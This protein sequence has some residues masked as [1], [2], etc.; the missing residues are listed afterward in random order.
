MGLAGPHVTELL[1]ELGP[2]VRGSALRELL[3]LPPRDVLL[4]L[5]PPACA[6]PEDER[7]RRLRVSAGPVG[8]RLHLQVGRVPRHRGPADPFFAEVAERLV[9]LRLAG[10]RQV[11]GDR[12]VRL[13][14]ADEE[15]RGR[16]V[17]VAE[18][19]G[20]HGNLVLLDHRDR[21]VEIL[22]PAR[23]K[24]AEAPR[25]VPGEGYAL[26][27]GR[28]GS[29]ADVLPLE[30]H[31]PAPPPGTGLAA[32][33]PLSWRVESSLGAEAEAALAEEQ[34]RDLSHRLQRRLKSA[35]KLLAGLAAL[36][37]AA[38][39]AERLRRDGELLKS[40]LPKLRRGAREVVVVDWFDEAAPSRTIPLDPKLSPTENLQR[41]FSRHQKLLRAAD[42]LPGEREMAAASHEALGALLERV[43]DPDT[44]PGALEEEAI[45][46]GWLA[47]RQGAPTRRAAPAKRLPYRTFTG[48]HGGEIRVGRSARD[49]DRLS[50]RESRGNDLWL[51]TSEAPGSHVVLRLAKGREPDPEDVLDAAHL[52]VHFSPLRGAAKA[53]IHVARV[54]E[55]KKPKKAPAGLV[56][57]AGGKVRMIR[58]EE[59][60]LRRLLDRRR[61]G[62]PRS[63]E[64]AGPSGP[65]A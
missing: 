48:L 1:A 21:V 20:R 50:F 52:A 62:P 16:A 49:N 34:R 58:I 26:P 28:T 33:A 18:L 59:D 51:H 30:R 56:T 22:V 44:D 60:R 23:G 57:L 10:L 32:L 40:E 15:G 25:L 64:D 12:V 45:A 38:A 11:Q 2:L 9:G 47:P 6:A 39:D 46:G 14:F 13:E 31:L 7:I 5:G 43:R 8:A 35:E 24:Q 54:K 61:P 53:G 17:L 4:V 63:G 42:N 37:A 27:P 65:R 3:P 41:L 19:L 36:E 55:L 29:P